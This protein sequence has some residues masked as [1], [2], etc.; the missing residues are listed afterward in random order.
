MKINNESIQEDKKIV[1]I[2]QRHKWDVNDTCER[3]QIKRKRIMNN[4]GLYIDHYWVNRQLT[5]I[6]QLC[7][8]K[9]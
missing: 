2:F 6:K 5:N 8:L 3:C 4:T 7:I 1:K 9:K